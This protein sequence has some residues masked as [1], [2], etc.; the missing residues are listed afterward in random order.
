[1][2][3]VF[4][5]WTDGYWVAFT[6]TDPS[7]SNIPRFG[8][9]GLFSELLVWVHEFTE[10]AIHEWMSTD[11]YYISHRA[12]HILTSLAVHSGVRTRQGLKM[13]GPDEYWKRATLG[14][15]KKLTFWWK[16]EET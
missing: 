1:M 13:I 5:P 4:Q 3:E 12:S 14:K 8:V 7:F 11:Y 10:M 6:E 15:Q 2:S 16:L 9:A